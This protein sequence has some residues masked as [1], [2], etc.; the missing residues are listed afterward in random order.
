MRAISRRAL[1]VAT[2]SALVR[3]PLMDEAVFNLILRVITRAPNSHDTLCRRDPD[4]AVDAAPV[5]AEPDRT[6]AP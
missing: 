6:S 3:T 2:D 5:D 4:V 1:C